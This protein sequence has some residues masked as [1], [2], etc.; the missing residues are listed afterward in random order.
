MKIN[1]FIDIEEEIRSALTG[2]ITTY[3]RPL[4]DNFTLPSILITSVGGAE[5]NMVDAYDVTVDARAEDEET[6]LETL[7]NAI[8]IIE[9]IA[10]SQ[11]T[12]LRYVT[13]NSL[14]SW[15]KDP[16]RQELAMCTARIRVYAHKE[17]TEVSLS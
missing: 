2:Y 11:N 13:I 3:V 7:R 17:T 12:A 9:K 6:A 16:V 4:P 15:G 14:M 8:G 5:A 10:E 1:R